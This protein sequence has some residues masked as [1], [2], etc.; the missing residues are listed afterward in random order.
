MTSENSVGDRQ[1]AAGAMVLADRGVVC[2]DEFDKM[3]DI[4]RVAIHEV[5]KAQPV[6]MQVHDLLLQPFSITSS[7][8]T[9]TCI[10][11]PRH[12]CQRHA[13][14]LL[15][16]CFEVY[17]CTDAT[18]SSL[19]KSCALEDR[20]PRRFVHILEHLMWKSQH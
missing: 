6:C 9:L 5:T 1:L 14:N 16:L 17:L 10:G 15:L 3:S 13:H 8:I 2:I 12:C 11:L 19:R 20:S 4:D 18:S 7:S